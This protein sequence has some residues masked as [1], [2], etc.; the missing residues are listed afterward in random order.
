MVCYQIYQL[1]ELTLIQLHLELTQMNLDPLIYIHLAPSEIL[2]YLYL[3]KNIRA[4]R[5]DSN[6]LCGTLSILKYN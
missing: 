1:N 2:D 3:K 5:V 6:N 4:K